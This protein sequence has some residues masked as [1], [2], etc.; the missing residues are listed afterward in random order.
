[1]KILDDVYYFAGRTNSFGGGDYDG[2]LGAVD[3]GGSLLWSR[4]YGGDRADGFNALDFNDCGGVIATGDTRSFT[5]GDLDVF[6]TRT[7]LNGVPFWTFHYGSD[8]DDL[9]WSVLGH[10]KEIYIAGYTEG[11]GNG[12]EGYLLHLDCDGNYVNDM[13]F[14]G[15]DV[16]L[17]DEFTEIQYNQFNDNL[18]LVGFMQDPPNGLGAYDVWLMEVDQNFNPLTPIRVYGGGK[19][20]QGWS[21]AVTNGIN[22]QWDY[23]MAGWTDSYQVFGGRD[24]YQV[25]ADQNGKSGCNESEP[26]IQQKQPGYG[27]RDF[28]TW[29][30]QVR[31][32]CSTDPEVRE[33]EEWKYICNSCGG[34]LNAP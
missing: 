24:L 27:P 10:K 12:R 22:A 6:V 13:A 15:A 25:R 30:P 21:L 2:W 23:V 17:D 28:A 31:V 11:V 5:A 16:G 14:G 29:W 18:S 8:V 9:A 33:N 26:K 3:N 7:D 1:V 32:I 4:V 19:D 34:F 20:D